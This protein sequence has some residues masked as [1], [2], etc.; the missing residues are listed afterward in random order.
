MDHVNPKGNPAKNAFGVSEFRKTGDPN[1]PFPFT[2]QSLKFCEIYAVSNRARQ[3]A[4]AVGWPPHQANDAANRWLKEPDVK[5]KITEIREQYA[6]ERNMTRDRISRRL[7]AIAFA[8]VRKMFREDG[9]LLPITELG[10]DEAAALAAFE[11]STDGEGNV[12]TKIKRWDPNKALDSLA[13][14]HG[15]NE[16]EKLLVNEDAAVVI[17]PRGEYKRLPT[18]EDDV[19]ETR[20]ITL[21]QGETFASEPGS[22]GSSI[23]DI[24]AE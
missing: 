24:E 6:F 7:E 2:E 15:F 23:T 19:D 12:T 13:K 16:P 1:T 11:V 17:V 22:K 4:I 14:L 8:D 21:L 20:E 9:S 3:S 5:K 18:S 10:E